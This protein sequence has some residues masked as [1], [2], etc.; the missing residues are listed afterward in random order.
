[1]VNRIKKL[2]T[3]RIIIAAV[4]IIAAVAAFTGIYS[5]IAG[6][7]QLQFAPALLRTAI[8]F[9][10]GALISLMALIFLTLILGRIYCSFLCPLGIL[11]DIIGFI[12]RRR[13]RPERNYK[14]LRYLVTGVVFGMFIFGW[15]S[16]FLLLDPYSNFGRIFSTFSIGAIVP[17]I[18]LAVLVLWKK[19]IFCTTL[20]PVGTVLGLLSRHSIYKIKLNHNCVACGKCV[21]VCPAGCIDITSRNI[22]NERC[23]R[24]LNCLGSC[25]VSG[26]EFTRTKPEQR[27][28]SEF[29]EARRDFLKL[30]GIILVGIS[31]G[32][33][34]A[35]TG[36][37]ALTRMAATL[38][39]LPPGAG[40]ARQFAAS[41]TSCQLCTS[42]CPS[43]IITPS[44]YG[45]GP[46][47]LD[48]SKGY[49]A[50]DCTTCS[51]I[52]PT[53]ALTPLTLA[54]KKKTKIA[55]AKFN[56]RNCIVFQEGIPCGE[57]SWICPTGAITLRK[58][59]APKLNTEKCIGCGACQYVCP[60]T[61]KAMTITDIAAQ[62]I[63]EI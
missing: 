49:C 10:A 63:L 22:D 23:I 24:C 25:G 5:S 19:R 48:L 56:P 1:M 6:I 33:A 39:I 45:N 54:T 18:V 8:Q 44:E 17:F 61:S 3:L 21:S 43:G 31:C 7:M 20:C 40:N 47:T 46:V 30:G 62:K 14:K 59:G 27:P 13:N 55:E 60:A 35:R 16:G 32:S 50:P 26:I 37:A 41:C 12:S 2:K 15:N 51:N 11:Q 9:S 53:G 28:T 4:V 34:I 52:C 38:R 58:S 42:N 36:A 29:S 57:C